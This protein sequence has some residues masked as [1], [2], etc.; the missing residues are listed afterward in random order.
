M[1]LTGYHNHPS[2][3]P[4]PSRRT[5]FTRQLETAIEV[6]D[7]TPVDHLV[8]GAHAIYSY[9]DES[10]IVLRKGLVADVER[11]T[12]RTLAW[13]GADLEQ[14]VQFSQREPRRETAG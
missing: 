10:L 8:L 14:K 11:D 6:L 7:L 13:A 2:G 5:L 1:I 4:I 12:P 9:Q 3:D